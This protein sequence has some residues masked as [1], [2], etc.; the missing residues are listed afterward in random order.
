V[1]DY[2]P[3][4]KLGCSIDDVVQKENN[5]YDFCSRSAGFDHDR[6]SLGITRKHVIISRSLDAFQ[7]MK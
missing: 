1:K 5:V 4:W 2:V 3:L 7:G 6:V